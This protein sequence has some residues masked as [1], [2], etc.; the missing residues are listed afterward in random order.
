VRRKADV[1]DDGRAPKRKAEAAT[2]DDRPSKR[3]QHEPSPAQK[4][5]KT[6]S[7]GTTSNASTVLQ[8][9]APARQHSDSTSS[10]CS[11]PEKPRPK[12]ED[13]IQDARLFQ[14]Y[15][16]RYKDLYDRI[17]SVSEKER[18]D[19]DMGDLWKMHKRLKEMKADI[20]GNWDKVEKV[21]KVNDKID[22]PMR[23]AIVAR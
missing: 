7:N 4:S 20:W 22:K 17:S 21:A 10:H 15:Y 8:R 14:K 12:R 6:L 2:N 13:V 9:V 23:Q 18:D 19:K 11:S 5:I 16:K 3:Q 1:A